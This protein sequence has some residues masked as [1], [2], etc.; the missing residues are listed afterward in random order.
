MGD[1]AG[2]SG[3]LSNSP[4]FLLTLF[5]LLH[6]SRVLRRQE[7]SSLVT[8]WEA[9]GMVRV[10][11]LLRPTSGAVL[12]LCSSYPATAPGASTEVVLREESGPR[13]LIPLRWKEILCLGGDVVPSCLSF[14][15]V[16]DQQITSGSPW[17]SSSTEKA[18][19]RKDRT[20]HTKASTAAT[21]WLK[22]VTNLLFQFPEGGGGR[23]IF[24]VGGRGP[25]EVGVCVYY[26]HSSTTTPASFLAQNPGPHLPWPRAT[27]G[28]IRH[29]SEL[30][31]MPSKQVWH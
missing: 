22:E 19:L 24:R 25:E 13:P 31:T 26:I 7:G 9:V 8:D 23:D 10:A 11:K 29:T 20:R 27:P 2:G 21:K 3:I 1:Q 17:R 14:L 12:N 16:Q 18:P 6:L 28:A 4:G 30:P 5:L 15:E